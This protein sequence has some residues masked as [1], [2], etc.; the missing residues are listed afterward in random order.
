MHSTIEKI[1]IP[2]KCSLPCCTNDAVAVIE[3]KKD[4]YSPR[5]F[6]CKEHI[7]EIS[8]F[9]INGKDEEHNE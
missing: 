3:N 9:K 5:F 4:I 6:I 8:K 2:K 1:K 7:K